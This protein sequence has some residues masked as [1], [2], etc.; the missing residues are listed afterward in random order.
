MIPHKN[1]FPLLAG[2]RVAIER[3]NRPATFTTKRKIENQYK[4]YKLEL[5]FVQT[6]KLIS[7]VTSWVNRIKDI[8]TKM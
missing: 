4:I 1:L 8:L 6:V 5:H 3:I 2:T 7:H